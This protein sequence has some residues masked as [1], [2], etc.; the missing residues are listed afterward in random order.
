MSKLINNYIITYAIVLT[1]VGTIISVYNNLIISQSA[2]TIGELGDAKNIA[3]KNRTY[4]LLGIL[5]IGL[6][7]FLQIV[8]LY[9]TAI[10]DIKVL[11]YIIVCNL[12][13][14]LSAY[15]VLRYFE[16]KV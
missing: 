2:G 16:K 9:M 5:S 12:V 3:I 6:G 4:I 14:I 15:F 8:M 1:V 13:I 10:T 7:S 11:C